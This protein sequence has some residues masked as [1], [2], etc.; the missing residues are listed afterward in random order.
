SHNLIE[1]MGSET[2]VE[3]ILAIL[4]PPIGVFL[5]YGCG[6]ITRNLSLFLHYFISSARG[7]IL[8]LFVVDDIGIHSWNY[9]CNL[10]IG[11]VVFSLWKGGTEMIIDV[12]LNVVVVVVLLFVL[13]L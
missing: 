6:V 10:C 12:V 11:R 1:D 9:I 3:I 5:R 8:D 7:G 13:D 2:F 4:L